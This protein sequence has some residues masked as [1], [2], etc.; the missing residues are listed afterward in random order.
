MM[1]L[2]LSAASIVLVAS[3]AAFFRAIKHA[4]EGY[5]NDAGFHE[6]IDRGIPANVVVVD[7]KERSSEHAA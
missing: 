5:E 4:P 2:A 3:F 6:G 7:F 1:T